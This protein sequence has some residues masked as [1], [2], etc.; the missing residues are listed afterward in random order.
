MKTRL[1]GALSDRQAADLHS[2]FLDDLSSRLVPAEHDVWLAWALE[3]GEALPATRFPGLRQLGDDLGERQ[4]RALAWATARWPFV[5]VV[6]SDHPTLGEERIGEAFELLESGADLVLGPAHDGGYYLLGIGGEALH[7][8]LFRGISWSSDGVLSEMLAN[9]ARLGVEAT[10]L[11]EERDIDTPA[12]LDWLSRQLTNDPT[13]CPATRALLVS[14]GR[15]PL[16]M[17]R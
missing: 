17:V 16:E 11:A 10:L 12:D 1:I 4:F 3:P 15:I 7:P 5:V 2:A 9:A 14:W 13:L 8:E 6:G